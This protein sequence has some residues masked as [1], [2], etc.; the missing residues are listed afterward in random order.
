MRKVK[1]MKNILKLLKVLYQLLIFIIIID[2][3]MSQCGIRWRGTCDRKSN[4]KRL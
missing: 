2:R 3:S 4:A 1:T